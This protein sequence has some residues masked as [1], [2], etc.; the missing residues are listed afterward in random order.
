MLR[1]R[2]IVIVFVIVFVIVIVIVFVFVIVFVVLAC[3][4]LFLLEVPSHLPFLA[5][6]FSLLTSI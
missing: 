1:N 4:R 5:S 2:Y 3:F 6:N